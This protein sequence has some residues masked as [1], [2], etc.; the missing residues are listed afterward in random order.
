MSL[1]IIPSF[2]FSVKHIYR[3]Y[4]TKALIHELSLC[5]YIHSFSQLLDLD[6]Q[7]NAA[8]GE[9]RSDSIW[10]NISEEK[11]QKELNLNF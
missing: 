8:V 7:V 2:S 6:P 11:G 9:K 3:F 1:C 4:D 5:R 10:V